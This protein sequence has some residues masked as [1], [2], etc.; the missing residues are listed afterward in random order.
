MKN[1][2]TNKRGCKFNATII[3]VGC[4]RK[5]SGGDELDME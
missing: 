1:S 3:E 4:G 2:K 5:P